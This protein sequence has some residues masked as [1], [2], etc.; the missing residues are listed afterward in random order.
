[1]TYLLFSLRDATN[2]IS[3]FGVGF[4]ERTWNRSFV[5]QQIVRNLSPN[6]NFLSITMIDL[7]KSLDVVDLMRSGAVIVAF[8]AT[9]FV[10]KRGQGSVWM[11]ADAIIA[12]VGGLSSFICPGVLMDYQVSAHISSLQIQ[13]LQK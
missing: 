3:N 13:R 8:V 9:V 12:L 7:I 11:K 6:I 1:M 4:E 10:D 2:Q 5:Y